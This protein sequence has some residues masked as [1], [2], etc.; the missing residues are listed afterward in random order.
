M[1]T[2]VEHARGRMT[3]GMIMGEALRLAR[4]KG[5]KTMTPHE[6]SEWADILFRHI[7]GYETSAR[8]ALGAARVGLDRL[9][10]LRRVR[11]TCEDPHTL[12]WRRLIETT[13]EDVQLDA[14]QIAHIIQAVWAF[15][16]NCR[17]SP[18]ALGHAGRP[19]VAALAAE[20]DAAY[21]RL[22][23]VCREVDDVSAEARD[24]AEDL[25]ELYDD[26]QR[27]HDHDVR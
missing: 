10:E 17:N 15:A 7:A 1:G 16:N 27:S 11:Y 26:L 13:Y 21:M 12:D 23:Y 25:I 6:V 18:S 20:A 9:E 3:R 8:D 2:T 22:V 19:L 4:L 24:I 14:Q 5:L